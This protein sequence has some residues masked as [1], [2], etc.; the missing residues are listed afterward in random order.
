[1]PYLTAAVVLV[2]VLG[3]ANLLLLIALARRIAAGGTAPAAGVAA[4]HRQSSFKLQ[5][6][7]KP[8]AFQTV[9]TAGDTL[10]LS[11]LAGSR[12]LVGFFA[13][14]CGQCH[15]QVPDFVELARS[16]P[17]GQSQVIAVVSGP[18]EPAA[19]FAE[20]LEGAASVVLE[21]SA[22]GVLGP[23]A[24]AFASYGWPS[25]YLLGPDSAVEAGETTITM[26][27]AGLTTAR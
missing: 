17:G 25:F 1:L 14:G 13:P 16:L 10:T 20:D 7:S 2:G 21:R 27:L 6:G 4:G 3:L 18:A 5:P 12:A 11:S 22:H 8:A 19:K 26:L 9:T 15:D 23:V 24:H